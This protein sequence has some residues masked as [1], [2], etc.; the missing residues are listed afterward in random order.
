MAAAKSR[1]HAGIQ[2]ITIAI[3]H[4]ITTSRHPHET[5]LLR[6]GQPP[7]SLPNHRCRRP[8]RWRRFAAADL[9]NR[10]SFVGGEDPWQKL[11][12]SIVSAQRLWHQRGKELQPQLW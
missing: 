3:A 12:T 4:A 2:D 9:D 11:D 5:A 7:W 10:L 6:F 8:S 1:P